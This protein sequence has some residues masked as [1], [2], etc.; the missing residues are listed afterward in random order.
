MN[1]KVE[2]IEEPEINASRLIKTPKVQ[3]FREIIN[4]NRLNRVRDFLEL[5]RSTTQ[6][7][8]IFVLRNRNDPLEINVARA[9]ESMDFRIETLVEMPILEQ[10][11]LFSSAQTIAGFHGAGLTN[12]IFANNL[13]KSTLIEVCP[14]ESK[15]RYWKKSIGGAC[16]QPFT[17]ELGSNYIFLELNP[18]VDPRKSIDSVLKKIL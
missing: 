10:I 9:F 4:R 14:T 2:Y 8:R 5:P 13:S 1:F 15:N 16:Y 18:L 7:S 17:M 11:D 3:G 12:L 6:K